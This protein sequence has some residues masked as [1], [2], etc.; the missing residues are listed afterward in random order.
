MYPGAKLKFKQTDYLISKQSHFIF[1]GLTWMS[2]VRSI[3]F[4]LECSEK[5]SLDNL[6]WM[7]YSFLKKTWTN[8]C[9]SFGKY[10]FIDIGEE[11]LI[12]SQNIINN[13]NLN[14]KW[15][16]FWPEVKSTSTTNKRLKDKKKQKMKEIFNNCL[17]TFE[18]EKKSDP[19]WDTE[20][21]MDFFRTKWIF[22]QSFCF[23]QC[24]SHFDK[25]IWKDCTDSSIFL[26]SKRAFSSNLRLIDNNCVSVLS[27]N[28]C[29]D[30][31]YWHKER[32]SIK[33]SVSVWII[34]HH[35]L[36][37]WHSLW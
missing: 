21:K 26:L 6:L 36:N 18:L 12:D 29:F 27:I 8:I 7:E 14:G 17:Y 15:V 11:G 4:R 22:N 3:F 10:L 5:K 9:V 13:N 25:W 28:D 32:Q 33:R 20:H 24:N 31:N 23:K 30:V 34:I 19:A 2:G 37:E 35:Q 16:G 1:D